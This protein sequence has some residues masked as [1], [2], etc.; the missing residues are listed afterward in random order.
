[1]FKDTDV[2]CFLGDS[3]TANGR[4]MAEVYQ[5]LKKKYKI[6]CYNCGVSGGSARKAVQYIQSECLIYNPDYVCVMFGVNDIDRE[7]YYKENSKLPNLEERKKAAIDFCVSSYRGII[8]QIASSGA[9]P[10]I[11]IP[12]PYDE[13]S[14]SGDENHHCQCGLDKLETEM[15][16]I[17]K[18]YNCP[19]VDFKRV[20]MPLLGTDGIMNPDRVHPTD[21]GQ[22]IMAQT[23]LSD[24]GEIDTPDYGKSFEFEEW[25]LK[26]FEAEQR[27]YALNFAE[28]AGLF[29]EG[30][31]K[32]RTYEEIKKIAKERYDLA[33]N[34]DEF[35]PKAYLTYIN[36]IDNRKKIIGE[37][38]RHTIW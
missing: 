4:W 3:I 1:M 38:V 8:E 29:D 33:E 14:T 31:A 25:N 2:I 7:L 30:W 20:F 35:I 36:E 27:L 13:V 11:C 28:F 23:F 9:V 16:L 21:R 32:G 37:I 24:L 5:I 18:E 22:H 12:V 6:K 10:I 19:V 34:K 15:R 17:A 26:R